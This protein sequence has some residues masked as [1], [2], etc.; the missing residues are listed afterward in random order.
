M[1]ACLQGW[2]DQHWLSC[3][4][5]DTVQ[6]NE[7]SYLDSISV[8]MALHTRYPG[9]DGHTGPPGSQL[10]RTLLLIDNF[11]EQCQVRAC[12]QRMGLPLSAYLGYD[13]SIVHHRHH[14][15]TAR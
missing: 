13:N 15:G 8:A 5:L 4:Y 11:F 6:S 2:W 10:A 14:A 7:T 1:L 9:H 3:P 12:V